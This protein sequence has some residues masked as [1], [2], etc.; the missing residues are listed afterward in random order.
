MVWDEGRAPSA[1]LPSL[2]FCSFMC[3]LATSPCW[4]W[5]TCWRPS[6]WVFSTA[7][8]GSQ[9]SWPWPRSHAS[10]QWKFQHRRKARRRAPYKPERWYHNTVAGS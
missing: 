7:T 9:W 5:S 1:V 6:E 8:A 10:S 4:P 3:I 2:L